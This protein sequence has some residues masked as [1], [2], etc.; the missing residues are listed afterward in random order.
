MLGGGASIINQVVLFNRAE[1]FGSRLS[2]FRVSVLS[3]GSE[4]FGEDFSAFLE[5]VPGV[6]IAVGSRNEARGLTFDH[7]HP[8]FDVDENSLALGAEAL[9]E[10]IRRYLA[11]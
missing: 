1:G 3:H 11:S 2:N 6:F 10:T 4:V 8:R 9:Y 5:R 7:H